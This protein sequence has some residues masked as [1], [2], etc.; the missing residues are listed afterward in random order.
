[1]AYVVGAGYPR[2]VGEDYVVGITQ[3]EFQ[4]LPPQ[5]RQRRYLASQAARGPTL[6]MPPSPAW[7]GGQH[8]MWGPGINPVHEGHVPLPLTPEANNGV[9]IST[10]PTVITFTARPQKPFKPTRLLVRTTKTG[11][12]ATGFI[13]GQVFCGTDLQ[14]AELGAFDLETMGAGN[15]FDTWISF[16]QLEP[17]MLL[18]IQANATLQPTTP[19]NI[20]TFMMILGHYMH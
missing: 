5:E 20:A 2:V 6:A 16:S 9:F 10:G 17:G 1:M 19:D 13:V 3:Q 4:Q 14:Q 8:A 11:A 15:A 12:T 18:R 7:R